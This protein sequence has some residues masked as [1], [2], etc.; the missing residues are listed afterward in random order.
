MKKFST[1]HMNSNLSSLLSLTQQ[2]VICIERYNKPYVICMSYKHYEE[3]IK[4]TDEDY[5]ILC[6]RSIRDGLL[7]EE[8][9]GEWLRNYLG[10]YSNDSN[11]LDG[12]I[13]NRIS[14]SFLCFFFSCINRKQ[15]GL[16]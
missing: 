15:V 10:G 3:M 12:F 1:S 2:E 16:V 8:E 5:I 9:C 14:F 11:F 6:E 7:D 4:R 13:L